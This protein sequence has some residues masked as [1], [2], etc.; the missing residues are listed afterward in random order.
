MSAVIHSYDR[1]R[2]LVLIHSDVSDVI[3]SAASTVHLWRAIL[4]YVNDINSK[5]ILRI[6]NSVH[7]ELK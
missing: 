7:C 6:I 1:K 4:R 3:G 5:L 2:I